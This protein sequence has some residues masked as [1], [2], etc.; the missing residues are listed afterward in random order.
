[1]MNRGDTIEFRIDRH[2]AVLGDGSGGWKTELNMVSWNGREPK[3]D[4]R[5]WDPEHKKM[6]K[7]ICLGTEEAVRLKDALLHYFDE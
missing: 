7:G 4:L 2:L 3:F 5:A 1:M 6:G